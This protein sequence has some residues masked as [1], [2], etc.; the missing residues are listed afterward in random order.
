MIAHPDGMRP[1]SSPF[2]KGTEGDLFIRTIPAAGG[3]RM[4]TRRS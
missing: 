3:Y 1:R 4:L 2:S